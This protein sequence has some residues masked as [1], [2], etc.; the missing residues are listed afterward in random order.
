LGGDSLQF[1][2]GEAEVSA[3]FQQPPQVGEEAHFRGGWLLPA[4]E[5]LLL[6]P[7]EVDQVQV[8]I[9]LVGKVLVDTALRDTRF[10]DNA[11]D[12]CGPEIV[13]GKLVDRNGG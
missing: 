10:R 8:E 2:L 4:E 7:G 3:N 1:G 11:G 9:F 12:R 5:F 13:L 6:L